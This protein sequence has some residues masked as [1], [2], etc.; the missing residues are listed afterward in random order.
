MKYLIFIGVM[1]LYFI[2]FIPLCMLWDFRLYK[3][4]WVIGAWYDRGHRLGVYK[5]RR[6]DWDSFEGLWYDHK[7]P[8]GKR[9]Y[10]GAKR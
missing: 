1:L 3:K 8:Y 4:N 9:R 6:Y 5:W 7:G 10:V 2:L